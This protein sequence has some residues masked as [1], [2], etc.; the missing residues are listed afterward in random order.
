MSVAM[1]L[2]VP[3]II[4]LE[5]GP[6]LLL[7]LFSVFPIIMDSIHP[8]DADAGRVDLFETDVATDTPVT[9]SYLE[10]GISTA[11]EVQ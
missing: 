7:K 6:P 11:L 3:P 5:S 4:G 2:L 10:V 1:F 9:E 8:V